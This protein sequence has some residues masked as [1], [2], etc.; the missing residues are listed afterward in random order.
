MSGYNKAMKV[1]YD[2]LE[3]VKESYEQHLE[4]FNKEEIRDF[5]DVFI[6][7]IDEAKTVGNSLQE[8][9]TI[10]KIN[11]IIGVQFKFP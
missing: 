11:S 4:T 5:M 10:V 9:I 2:V 8:K 6:Q 7:K 3:I 1:F